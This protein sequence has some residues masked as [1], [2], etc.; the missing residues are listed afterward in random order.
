MLT[1]R[2]DDRVGRVLGDRYRLHA[3]VGVGGQAR[4]YLADDVRLR[5]Q[6]AVKMLHAGLARNSVFL[7]RF[8][9]EA[10]AAAA[11]SHPNLLAVFDH[12]EEDDGPFL[13]TEFLGGGSLRSLLDEHGPLSPSQALKVA[14][15]SAAGLHAAH[16]RGMV[17]RDIKP[18]N[19][20]F[21]DEGRL[22]IADFGLVR[23]LHEAALTEPDGSV[24]GTA[25]YLPPEAGS[26]R[27][28]YERSDVYSLGL[29]VVEAVTGEVPLAG[30]S[31][32]EVLARRR[33]VARIELPERL[34]PAGPVLSTALRRDPD[35]R[36][37]ALE[38]G[39]ALIATT[40]SYRPPDP[41]P[42]V[43][44]V[45]GP[46]DGDRTALVDP[47][48]ATDGDIS[49]DDEPV[50]EV[51]SRIERR[52]D[53]RSRRRAA[54]EPRRDDRAPVAAEVM[55]PRGRLRWLRNL[56]LGIALVA[57]AGFVAS[58]MLEEQPVVTAM[59]E[60]QGRP[61]EALEGFAA[62][63]GWDLD[64][65]TAFDDTID[66]GQ[67][68]STNPGDGAEV[69][70]GETVSVVVSDGP[71]PVE[72]ADLTGLELNEASDQ[73]SELG[74]LLGGSP[75][76]N[77]EEV[78]AGTVLRVEIDGAV[79]TDWPQSLPPGTAVFLVVS[80]GP[81]DRI[82]PEV[83]GATLEDATNRLTE[84][85]LVIAQAEDAFS[86]TVEAGRI[87]DQLP[88][89]GAQLER[90]GTVTVT[91]SKGPDRRQVPELENLTIDQARSAL[92]SVG[93]ALGQVFGPPE[94]EV[95]VGYASGQGPGSSHAPGTA[96]DVV[97]GF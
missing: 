32:D 1:Q 53:R 11:L 81:Q 69:E 48:D 57:I 10:R 90:D 37:T 35:E 82:V 20:L 75:A 7:R 73:L 95:I 60:W 89:P 58:I 8:T 49:V 74:L 68:I 94:A 31:V 44:T 36:P 65:T 45:T 13:V 83:R 27:P 80:N 55:P 67:I 96:I 42:L 2:G 62:G 59:G 92:E 14:M 66:A 43:R 88:L 30:G 52:S 28:L 61:I 12:G 9:A 5:R 4:V 41:L 26:V 77:D 3:L 33:S 23:A 87:I 17:H 51:R 63:S 84:E 93:L 29:T 16:S 71:R 91:V 34:G 25:R 40:S 76:E 22:R 78:P 56:V 85:L 64:V 50:R 86:E 21:G 39:K 70:E 79:V 19:L 54:V 6:V 24:Q 47:P 46:L 97:A 38:L 72:L 15:E 18:A